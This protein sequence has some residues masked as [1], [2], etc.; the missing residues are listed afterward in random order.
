M[1]DTIAEKT[2]DTALSK[3]EYEPLFSSL[4]EAPIE[5]SGQNGSVSGIVRMNTGTDIFCCF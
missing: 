5:Q 1:D 3:E 4:K 2:E